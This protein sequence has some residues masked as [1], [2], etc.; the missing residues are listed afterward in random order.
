MRDVALKVPLRP[1]S[2]GGLGQTDDVDLAGVEPFG[3]C[4]DQPALAGGVSPFDQ[5]E[6]A[7]ARMLQPAG[8]IVQLDLH[9]FEQ[10]F[11]LFLFEFV[12]A[13]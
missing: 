2:L 3:N 6:H 13:G 4:A 8:E 5:H 9:R 7:C 1:L 12:H 11:G 10:V